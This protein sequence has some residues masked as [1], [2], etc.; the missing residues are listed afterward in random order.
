VINVF[1]WAATGRP[2]PPDTIRN[3]YRFVFWRSGDLEYCAVSDTARDELDG[4]VRL[5]QDLAARG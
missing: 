4:L 5:L 1:S 3:G 2:T